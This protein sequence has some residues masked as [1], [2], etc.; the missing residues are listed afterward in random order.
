MMR[1]K[2]YSIAL[3]ATLFLWLSGCNWQGESQRDNTQDDLKVVLQIPAQQTRDPIATIPKAPVDGTIA[4]AFSRA[5]DP[6]SFTL[7]SFLVSTGGNPLSGV[8]LHRTTSS[9]PNGFVVFQPATLLAYA[10]SYTVTIKAGVRAL[11]GALLSSDYTWDFTTVP[12]PAANPP[13][14]SAALSIAQAGPLATSSI[15]CETPAAAIQND[16]KVI[17][18]GHINGTN[19]TEFT[20]VRYNANGGLDTTFGGDGITTAVIGG[21]NSRALAATVQADGKVVAVGVSSNATDKD[22]ALA[23]YLAD[24]SFDPTFSDDGRRH[25]DLG[26]GDERA[27]AV[28]VQADN[29]I[30]VAGSGNDGTAFILARYNVDGSADTA[31]GANGIASASATVSGEASYAMVLQGNQIVVASKALVGAAQATVTRY[32][33]DGSVDLTFNGGVPLALPLAVQQATATLAAHADG[34]IALVQHTGAGATAQFT[35]LGYLVY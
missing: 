35:V 23:R 13:V 20:V 24:G 6:C 32:N 12:Q 10:T 16:G 11:N 30:M 22:F 33:A 27:L 28:A 21:G 4:V 14:G 9:Y 2:T 1:K 7:E 29:K 25:A 5:M 26:T 19:F 34:R 8:I 3:A 18:A 15:T 17:A 31:F